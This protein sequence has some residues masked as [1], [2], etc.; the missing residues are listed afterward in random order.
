M[1][2]WLYFVYTLTTL[3]IKTYYSISQAMTKGTTVVLEETFRAVPIIIGTYCVFITVIFL[4]LIRQRFR[5]LNKT[6]APHMSG[7]P[8]T[9]SQGE[10]TVY[11]VRYLHGVLIDSAEL[12]DSLYGIGSLITFTSILLE[13]VSVLYLFIEDIDNENT[14]VVILDLSFQAV[15][16]FAMYHMTAVEV[17]GVIFHYSVRPRRVLH[18]S[19]S[20]DP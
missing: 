10:I 3:L 12:I 16:L 19:R 5:H 18:E 6:I 17:S 13:F 7:L 1:F 11:D 14:M 8:V 9:G 2:T 4:D 15:F 20:V